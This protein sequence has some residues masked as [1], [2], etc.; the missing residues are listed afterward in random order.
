MTA[1]QEPAVTTDH[2]LVGSKNGRVG[3]SSGMTAEVCAPG[4]EAGPRS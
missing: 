2:H 4:R 3:Q 1:Q